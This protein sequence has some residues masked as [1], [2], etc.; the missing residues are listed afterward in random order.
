VSS[1]SS[2]VISRQGVSSRYY[3]IS[4]ISKNVD[5]G[6]PRVSIVVLASMLRARNDRGV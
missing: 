2:L 3:I 5:L 6:L 4:C 1:E